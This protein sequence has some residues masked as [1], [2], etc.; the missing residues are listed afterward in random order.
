VLRSVPEDAVVISDDWPV[1]TGLVAIREIDGVG[2]GVEVARVSADP[3]GAQ[4]VAAWLRGEDALILLE[5]HKEL[6]TPRPVR[7]YDPRLL[8]HLQELGL[9]ATPAEAGTFRVSL[10]P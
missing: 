8:P 6:T 9:R 4:R 7:I 1:R 5:E 2:S 10:E 3:A